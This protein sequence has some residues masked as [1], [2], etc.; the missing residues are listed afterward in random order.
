MSDPPEAAAPTPSPSQP[1]GDTGLDRVILFSDAVVAIAI[2]LL[3]LPLLDVADE[4]GPI[5]DVLGNASSQILM[6]FVSFAVVA[7]FWVNHR[8]IFQGVARVS[9]LM[10]WANMAWLAAIAFLPFPSEVLG[11]RGPDEAGVR[12]FYVGTMWACSLAQVLLS[13]VI[14]RSPGLWRTDERP[15]ISL[16]ASIASAVLFG[17]IFVVAVA[18]P[19]IGLYALLGLFLIGPLTSALDRRSAAR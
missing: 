11:D 13:V 16:S 3:V 7:S 4:K 15:E 18:V 1:E 17:I 2:T 19:S 14:V 12:A 6:F 5:G 10:I 8:E 9:P